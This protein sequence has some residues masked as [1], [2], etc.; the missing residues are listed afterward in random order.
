M[1]W[2]VVSILI[3]AGVLAGVL[4]GFFGVGGGLIL[5][6]ALIFFLGYSQHAANG[7]SLVALLP[8]V[9]LLGVV[10]YYQAGKINTDNIKA[11]LILALGM[12]LGAYAGGRMAVGLSAVSLR[13]TFAVFLL[14]AAAK[15]WTSK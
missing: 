6:P 8:P 10:A 12:F 15:L 14:I 13:R 1:T 9:G 2:S 3:T 4:A 5:I 7:T 11:G